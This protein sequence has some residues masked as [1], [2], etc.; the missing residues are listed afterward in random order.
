[1][2]CI[3]AFVILAVIVLCIPVIRIFSKKTAN[4]IWN[5]F[6]KATYCVTRRV[7]FRKCD[8]SFKSDIKNSILRKVVLK[9]PKWVKP[10]SVII[11]TLAAFIVVIS[12]WSLLVAAKS[13]LSL[14]VY[15]TCDIA[16]PSSCSL[17][18]EACSIDSQP[19]DF[20][21]NPIKW[22][23]NWF[24][25]FGDVI[26]N[27]PTRL[28]N[29]DANDYIS[30]N[31]QPYNEFGWKSNAL[32]ILD[33]GCVVCQQSFRNQLSGGFFDKYNVA[34][35]LYPIKDPDGDYKFANSYLITSYIEAARLK[36]LENS[37][38]PI[39]WL[40]IEKLFTEKDTDGREFQVAFN[41]SYDEA[42]ARKVLENWLK[43]FGY[44]E[45]EISE[46]ANLAKSDQ[47]RKIIEKNVS[48]MDNEI[49]SKRIPTMIFDGRR[50]D[51]MWTE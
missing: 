2:V 47:V 18:G 45:S 10:L 31:A 16:T 23:G 5:L 24:A 37:E 3:A 26:V 11:E 28:R 48:V 32:D 50:H 6:K 12:I 25:E 7:T 42:T 40:I 51:G 4:S 20:W 1:M 34:L 33:P 9:R 44:S 22:T 8:S 29:W 30:Q 38:R 49:R 21:Q 13:G 15:G 41:I 43:E 46:I 36:R 14:F 19:I 27:I 35:M 17:S 39:E